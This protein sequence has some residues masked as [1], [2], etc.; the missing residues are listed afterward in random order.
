MKCVINVALINV[1]LISSGCY[2]IEEG[3]TDM[4][5][6]WIK[7]IDWISVALGIGASIVVT[8]GVITW[9]GH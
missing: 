5:V 6:A 3:A 9:K 2:V 1:A 8:F 4:I 7:R